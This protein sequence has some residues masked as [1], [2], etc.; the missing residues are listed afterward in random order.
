[1]NDI[2]N[3]VKNILVDKQMKIVNSKILENEVTNELTPNGF[4]LG[5]K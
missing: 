1:M 3:N 2:V 5:R 4:G